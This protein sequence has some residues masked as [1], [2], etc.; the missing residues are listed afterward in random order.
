MKR[1]FE[2][3]VAADLPKTRLNEPNLPWKLSEEDLYRL[4]K[5]GDG[6]KA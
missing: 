5:S 3:N 2:S 6:V 4:K 1:R